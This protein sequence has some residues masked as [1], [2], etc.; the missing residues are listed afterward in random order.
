MATTTDRQRQ[1]LSNAVAGIAA[2]IV[3]SIIL[4]TYQLVEIHHERQRQINFAG[5]MV[6]T[7]IKRIEDADGASDRLLCYNMLLRRLEQL[8]QL[9][10][11]VI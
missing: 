11:S 4:G 3:V 2:G 6:A 7:A 9:Q 1:I 5:D 10:P 8:S